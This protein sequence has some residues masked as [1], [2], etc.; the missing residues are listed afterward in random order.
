MST[1]APAHAFTSRHQESE[2]RGRTAY[3]F[4]VER[5]PDMHL[6]PGVPCMWA[7]TACSTLMRRH[8]SPPGKLEGLGFTR[9]QLFAEWHRITPAWARAADGEPTS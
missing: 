3:R 1:P 7:V 9:G 5:C 4:I 2:L 8:E 6:T